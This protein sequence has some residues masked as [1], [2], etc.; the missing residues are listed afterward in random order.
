[1]CDFT[2]NEA[3]PNWKLMDPSVFKME[4]HSVEGFDE[5]EESVIPIPIQYGG[6]LEVNLDQ[7]NAENTAAPNISASTNEAIGIIKGKKMEGL[8]TETVSPTSK[9]TDDPTI[10][11][12]MN[13]TADLSRKSASP[14]RWPGQ[15]AGSGSHA[16]DIN[17]LTQGAGDVSLGSV[18]NMTN[19]S[20]VRGH[21]PQS[22]SLGGVFAS[23]EDS[24]RQQAFEQREAAR[25]RSIYE[26]AVTRCNPEL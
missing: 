15:Q 12:P 17:N 10:T 22:P 13:N 26:K 21:A 5:P 8:S 11:T 6:E 7:I 20:P 19:Q 3:V 14:E 25:M 24:E 1:M 4:V 23:N 16:F 2:K 9:Q 18:S